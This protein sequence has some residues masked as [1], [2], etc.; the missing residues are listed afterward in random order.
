[1]GTSGKTVRFAAV[2]TKGGPPTTY[3]LWSDPRKDAKF[4]RAVAEHQVMTV[5]REVRGPHKDHGEVGYQPDRHA[6]FL[7]FP[8]S[9]RRF[10]GKRVVGIDYDLLTHETASAPAIARD[11]P[12]SATRRAA[13]PDRKPAENVFHFT[14][15]KE[16]A[17]QQS[18][19]APAEQRPKRVVTAKPAHPLDPETAG[20]IRRAVRELKSGKYIAA[21][22]RLHALL[23]PR[24]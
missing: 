10:E 13:P 21:Y 9:L 2:V 19:K 1:M 20:E 14:E 23:G 5:H 8:K 22:H 4:R 11:R 12:K 15:P 17:L 18:A 3:L 6:L 7:L 24:E 16:E